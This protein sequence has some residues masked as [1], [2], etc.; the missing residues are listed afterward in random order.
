M[1]RKKSTTAVAVVEVYY[2]VAGSVSG[3]GAGASVTTGGGGASVTTGAS[4]A[5]ASVTAGSVTAGAGGSVLG[6]EV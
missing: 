1:E 3:G 4:V 5:G 2:G 6:A